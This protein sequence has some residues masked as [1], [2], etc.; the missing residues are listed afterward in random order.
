[1]VAL[2][3]RNRAIERRRQEKRDAT[4]RAG[5]IASESE[6]ANQQ[7]RKKPIRTLRG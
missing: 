7:R 2:E 6:T 3:K 1:M 5:V 4:A